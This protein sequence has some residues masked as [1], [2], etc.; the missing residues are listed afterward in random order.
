MSRESGAP[1]PGGYKK[2]PPGGAVAPNAGGISFV[3]DGKWRA[4]SGHKNV[5]FVGNLIDSGA[6]VAQTRGVSNVRTD[7]K[8]TSIT[9]AW[10]LP[11]RPGGSTATVTSG[12]ATPT[13]TFTPDVAGSYTF[14]V[15]V[16]F[17]GSDAP[18]T[19]Q[20]DFVYVSA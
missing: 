15:V 3:G 14:R 13:A 19:I 11:T 1:T 10:T 6:R 16:T 2:R 5:D 20:Q 12:A 17:V 9:Y 7:A 4:F 18:N 8:T